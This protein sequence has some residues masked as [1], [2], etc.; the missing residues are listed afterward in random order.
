MNNKNGK[1]TL[2]NGVPIDAEMVFMGMNDTDL[3]NYYFLDIQTGEVIFFNEFD[4]AESEK[5][6][7]DIENQNY[8]YVSVPRLQSYE[9]YKWMESFAK[10]VAEKDAHLGEKLAI[11]LDGKGAFSR[12][13]NVLFNAGGDWR[14]QWYE[15][16]NNYLQNEL[17]DWLGSLKI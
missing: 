2:P 5:Q 7:E 6:K 10:T 17:Q 11:A 4:G 8:R 14:Q 3:T 16:E 12:F 13:K 15:Y 9:K 1:I